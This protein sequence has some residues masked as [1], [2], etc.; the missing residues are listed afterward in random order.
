[1][2][3]DGD[4]EKPEDDETTPRPGDDLA[5]KAEIEEAITSLYK[6]ESKKKRLVAVAALILRGKSHLKRQFQPED[7]FQEALERIGIGLRTWP[8]SRV[9]FSGLVI[10]VMR[11]WASS[12]EKTKS[13]QDEKVIMEHELASAEEGDEALKLEEIAAD[14]STPLEQLEAEE[15][16]HQGQSLL[17]IL[18]AQYEPQELTAKIL[19]AII[20]EPFETHEEIRFALGVN[21]ADYRNAWKVLMRAAKKLEPKE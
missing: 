10:G 20:K 16:D 14:S 13:T 19:D 11:S 8:K 18:K 3:T 9:D 4:D 12:L 7:L 21:E 5:S 2:R 17:V 1:V 6:D 15:L